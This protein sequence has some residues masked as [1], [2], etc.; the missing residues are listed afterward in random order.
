MRPGL[1]AEAARQRVARL[2]DCAGAC[3]ERRVYYPFFRYGVSAR[4]RWLF[5]H[6][7]LEFDCVVDARN[8]RAA[9]AD[10]LTVD[11]LVVGDDECMRAVTG[12][13][14]ARHSAQ[15]YA[16]HSLGKA[17]R[18][19][20]NFNLSLDARGLVHRP[21]WIV[22]TGTIRVLVDAVT[23]DLHPLACLPCETAP[24]APASD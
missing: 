13:A 18:M 1:D 20:G 2:Q 9:S 8:G 19:L 21:Y 24:A 16:A 15:R 7:R 6:E 5:G 11:D 12:E 14:D 4:V 3:V 17:M 22:R 23:G 10:E